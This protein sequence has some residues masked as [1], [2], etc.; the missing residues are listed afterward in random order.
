[1]PGAPEGTKENPSV[2]M[3][4][5]RLTLPVGAGPDI[6]YPCI[7]VL[8]ARWGQRRGLSVQALSVE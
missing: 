3:R 2:R 7:L 6:F 8:G 5:P 1:M 4:M